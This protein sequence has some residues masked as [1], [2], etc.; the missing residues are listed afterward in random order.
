MELYS[1]H[2]V[3]AYEGKT[4]VWWKVMADYRWV[5]T[6]SHLGADCTLGSAPGPTLGNEYGRTLPLVVDN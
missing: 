6:Y 5:M 2:L 4:R 1:V 3:N